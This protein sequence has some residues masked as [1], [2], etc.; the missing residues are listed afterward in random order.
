MK[1]DFNAIAQGYTVDVIAQFLQAK[2]NSNYL[3]EVGGELLAKGKN[4]D[5]NT[6]R[7]GVDKPSEDIDENEYQRFSKYVQ[8][9]NL[10]N[11]LEMDDNTNLQGELACAGGA[12]EIV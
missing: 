6:W 7:V 11:V 1:L 9:I 4:A 10:E 12:C 5:E 2:E 8:E 3:I